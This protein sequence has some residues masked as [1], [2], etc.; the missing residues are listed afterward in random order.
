MLYCQWLV[1]GLYLLCTLSNIVHLNS[2]LILVINRGVGGFTW[3]CHNP[4]TEQSRES[5]EQ[6]PPPSVRM[7]LSSAGLQNMGEVGCFLPNCCAF[8][9]FIQAFSDKGGPERKHPKSN[10]GVGASAHLMAAEISVLVVM[11]DVL[12]CSQE[13]GRG[14]GPGAP[15]L[16]L[17]CPSFWL[18]CQHHQSKG[19][20]S[21]PQRAGKQRR[22]DSN[23]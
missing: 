16:F 20:A 23:W 17:K 6:L 8:M 15:V 4:G 12:R 21:V 18:R 22:K 13:G 9:L 1:A 3:D 14:E 19:C 5:G 10:A 11:E 7:M 2:T